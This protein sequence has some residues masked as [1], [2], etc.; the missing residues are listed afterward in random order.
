[1]SGK[2][3]V[4]KQDYL[5]GNKT[6]QEKPY[7]DDVEVGAHDPYEA[8]R[9]T[10]DCCEVPEVEELVTDDDLSF[11]DRYNNHKNVKNPARKEEIISP[12]PERATISRELKTISRNHGKPK[13]TEQILFDQLIKSLKDEDDVRL[14]EF[15]I[16][17]LTSI[18]DGVWNIVRETAELHGE[19][20]PL[21]IERMKL[22]VRVK[23]ALV[24]L[25]VG[26]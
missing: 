1:M 16:P 14:Q 4:S 11:M 10:E 18:L 7:E 8:M 26:S 19:D 22:Y 23:I 17:L 21:F 3:N 5:F 15:G 13:T 12:R 2:K 25:K 6:D 9:Q 20:S 24:D